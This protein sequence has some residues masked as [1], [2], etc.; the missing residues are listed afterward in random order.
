[1]KEAMPICHNMNRP[2]EYYDMW[3]K[4]EKKN[5]FMIPLICSIKK[6][7]KMSIITKK[8][9]TYRYRRQSSVCQRGGVGGMSEISEG[10]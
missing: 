7:N 6:K 4:S 10:D 3:N 9:Q 5:N 2:R 8:K 1:M